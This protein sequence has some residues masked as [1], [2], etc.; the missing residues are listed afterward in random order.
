MADAETWSRR[1]E[2]AST[3]VQR[4]NYAVVTDALTN[5]GRVVCVAG[6]GPSVPAVVTD[7]LTM[8]N[9]TV[10]A[11]GMEQRLLPERIAMLKDAPTNP[12]KEEFAQGMGPKE[13]VE[14]SI[15]VA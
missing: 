6:M 13:R 11:S 1:M 4:S 3:M 15:V 8:S 2:S 9:G 7:A 12:T 10:S 5:P 14:V